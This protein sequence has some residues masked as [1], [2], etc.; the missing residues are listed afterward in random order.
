MPSN[1][2]KYIGNQHSSHCYKLCLPNAFFFSE[3][4]IVKEQLY[5]Q[6]LELGITF[7]SLSKNITFDHY[8][9]KPKSMHEWKL[10]AMLHKDPVIVHS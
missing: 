5:F 4:K 1:Q 7:I 9:T 6:I 2:N 8:L 3:I 10:L